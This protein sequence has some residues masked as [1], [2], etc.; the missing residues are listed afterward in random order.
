[1][2]KYLPSILKQ[3]RDRELSTY[4]T[5]IENKNLQKELEYKMR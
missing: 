1:M 3:L 5:G 4:V 2:A